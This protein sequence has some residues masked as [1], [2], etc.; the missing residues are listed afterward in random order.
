VVDEPVKDSALARKAP[1][2][3]LQRPRQNQDIV[4]E[5]ELL[6]AA[7]AAWRSDEPARALAT[8]EQHQR[9]YPRSELAQE[10]EALHVLILCALGRVPEAQRRAHKLLERAP[11]LP[12]RAA[13]EES[14]AVRKAALK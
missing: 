1:V 5:L 9:R 4:R 13:I 2:A 7:Q 3:T 14:C 8:I 10:R 6:H 12:L 11:Q